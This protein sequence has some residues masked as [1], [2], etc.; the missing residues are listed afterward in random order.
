MKLVISER[1][2]NELIT[3][4]NLNKEITEQGDGEGAPE[5]GTSSDGEQKTGASKWESG[6][7][8]GPANQ[9]GVTKWADSYKITRGRANPLS[10]Q[11]DFMM[12]RRGNA[13]LNATGIRSDKDYQKVN[14]SIDA[15]SKLTLGT[16]KISKYVYKADDGDNL[17]INLMKGEFSEALLDLRSVIFTPGGM[18]AQ[19]TIEIV[20]SETIVV[21][22][23]IEALNAAILINDWDLYKTQADRDPEAGY[24]VIEDILLYITRG[25]FKL[26][27]NALKTWLKTPAG[28]AYMKS[29]ADNVSK[30]ITSIKSNINKLPNSGLKK[31]ISSKL[32]SFDNSFTGFLRNITGKMVSK[33]PSKLRKGIIGGLLVYISAAAIDKLIGAPKG[34]TNAELAKEGGPS[35][36]Y[37]DK[38]VGMGKPKISPQ[39][40]KTTEDL[41][42]LS[43]KGDLKTYAEQAILV[44]K[45]GYPC[46][47]SYY[48]KNQFVV[49]ASTEEMD[50][51]KI[52]N[53]EYYDTGSGIFETQTGK[54]LVC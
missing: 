16:N 29:I 13:L 30:Y 25:A 7:T 42:I 8:R 45:N 23:V 54:E 21:P 52:N 15:A 4:L 5:A 12:D 43:K 47:S 10:E 34:T 36:E 48:K 26:T 50:I 31:Y 27:G 11:S 1:Q 35:D 46:L 3:Q 44:Y 6:V 39:D 53:K 18:A 22:V 19:T 32:G 28:K 49:L 20:F 41:N 37:M 38:V 9:I 17:F 51:F 24:R 33:I 2:L 40:I 14:R